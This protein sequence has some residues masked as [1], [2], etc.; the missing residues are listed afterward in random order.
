MPKTQDLPTPLCK[1]GYPEEQLHEIL[2]DKFVEFSH[3]M[4]GQTVTI[5]DGQEYD[6]EAKAYKP[7]NCGPHGPVVYAWDLS[8]FLEGKDPLD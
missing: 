2:G 3:W 6:H 4:A 1:F 5:C 7:T 8:R